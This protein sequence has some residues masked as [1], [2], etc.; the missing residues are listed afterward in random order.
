MFVIDHYVKR[1]A[2]VV[3]W[4]FL[5]GFSLTIKENALE[6]LYFM[7]YTYVSLLMSVRERY[8]ND[9]GCYFQDK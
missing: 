9:S 3:L 6:I 4:V 7:V 1:S 2:K 5:Q 8:N